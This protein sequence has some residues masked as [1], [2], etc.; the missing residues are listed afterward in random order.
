M[1]L[2][3]LQLERFSIFFSL[4]L[5]H[6]KSFVLFFGKMLISNWSQHVCCCCVFKLRKHRARYSDVHDDRA[7]PEILVEDRQSEGFAVSPTQPID[8]LAP[9]LLAMDSSLAKQH[10]Y[11]LKI[12]KSKKF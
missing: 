11:R 4:F 5:L 6:N 9:L 2:N 8:Q 12:R 1:R 3:N 7:I 10:R